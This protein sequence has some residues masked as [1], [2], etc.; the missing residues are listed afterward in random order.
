MP[1]DTLKPGEAYIGLLN[2]LLKDLGVSGD[3]LASEDAAFGLSFSA[4]GHICRLLP[5]P[6]VADRLIAEVTVGNLGLDH[7]PPAAVNALHEV[8]NRLN[9]A[10][11][12]EHD[13]VAAVDENNEVILWTWRDV[14]PMAASAVQAL[15]AEGLDRAQT[16]SDMLQTAGTHLASG[17]SPD[18]TQPSAAPGGSVGGQGPGWSALRG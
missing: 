8:I 17:P 7:L 5:H 16:L 15:L 4:D 3:G 13:W 11:R 2:H 12:L 9:A 14:Q 1:S 10:A 18:S 6:S